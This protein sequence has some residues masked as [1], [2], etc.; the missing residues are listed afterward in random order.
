MARLAPPRKF[1]LP[2]PIKY[3]PHARGVLLFNP[4]SFN[5]NSL[6]PLL[7]GPFGVAVS[8]LFRA[9]ILASK[10]HAVAQS[11]V[12]MCVWQ[13]PAPLRRGGPPRLLKLHRAMSLPQA[14]VPH[15]EFKANAHAHSPPSLAPST[16]GG[17]GVVEVLASD[18]SGVG[19]AGFEKI[20]LDSHHLLFDTIERDQTILLDI[21]VCDTLIPLNSI[22]PATADTT[23]GRHLLEESPVDD[24]VNLDMQTHEIQVIRKSAPP[25]DS[26]GFC[27]SSAAQRSMRD[28]LL[29]IARLAKPQVKF[30]WRILS[31]IYPH[32]KSVESLAEEAK[33]FHDCLC[34]GWSREDLLISAANAMAAYFELAEISPRLPAARA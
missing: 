21:A 31:R 32:Y 9:F 30:N 3:I 27:R 26:G 22:P 23:A 8:T 11:T 24:A 17:P 5:L 13:R 12:P 15:P 28:V 7:R 2:M 25:F 19:A 6:P 29:E 1:L 10:L 20:P 33:K 4:C 16:V 34:R 14:Y 18:P